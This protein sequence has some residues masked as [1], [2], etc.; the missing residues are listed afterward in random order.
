MKNKI[1]LFTLMLMMSFSTSFAGTSTGVN[2]RI[3]NSFKKT[4][5]LLKMFAGKRAATS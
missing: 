5:L 1:V 3:A 2:D 4:L